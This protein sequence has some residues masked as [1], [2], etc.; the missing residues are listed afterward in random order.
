MQDQGE[1][2]PD[3]IY[4][5]PDFPNLLKVLENQFEPPEDPPIQKVEVKPE[6][7]GGYFDPRCRNDFE[8]MLYLGRLTKTFSWSGHKI[9]IQ[10][11]DQEGYLELGEIVKRYEDTWGA[12]RAQVSA[13]VA[14]CIVSIDNKGWPVPLM[15]DESLLDT[16]FAWIIKLHPFAIDAIY[17]EFMILEAKVFEVL[18]EMGKGSGASWPPGLNLT[19]ESQIEEVSSS[20]V[21]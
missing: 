2:S 13:T 16:K 21:D 15:E 9:K 6:K 7:V 11:I 10:T 4:G 20:A 18:E 12:I 17:N 19:S 14:G 1:K 5:T 8:G 3:D